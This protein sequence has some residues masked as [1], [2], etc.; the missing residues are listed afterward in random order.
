MAVISP[1]SFKTKSGVPVVVRS[2]LASD[3]SQILEVVKE[4]INEEIY[5]LTSGLEFN[6]TLKDEEKF[7]QTHL[8]NP[9][10]VL[11]VAEI[12]MRVVGILDFTN[13]HRNR[14]AHTGDFG[15]SVDKKFRNQGIGYLLLQSLV[16][17]AT[18]NE[19]IEKIGLSVHSNNERAIA[20]YKKMGF[21]IEGIKKRE[22]KYGEDQ[23][24]DTVVMGKLV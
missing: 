7:I 15:M 20:L 21:E 9:N 4:V 24:I 13:G 1:K 12:E 17:W 8:E 23:Y 14:I 22:L 18:H 16:D 2:A 11:L 3:A 5:Q 6:L 19:T 10:H